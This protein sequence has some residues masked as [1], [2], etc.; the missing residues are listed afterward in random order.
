MYPFFT[1]MTYI[2]EKCK[3]STNSRQASTRSMTLQCSVFILSCGQRET[4]AKKLQ[5]L[6]LI[7]NTRGCCFEAQQRKIVRNLL[8]YKETAN[9][10]LLN[11]VYAVYYELKFPF[12]KKTKLLSLWA[13]LNSVLLKSYWSPSHIVYLKFLYIIQLIFKYRWRFYI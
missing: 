13:P 11:F 4:W 9:I 2:S 8:S 6:L 10:K 3:T 12:L 7:E 1:L 5:L